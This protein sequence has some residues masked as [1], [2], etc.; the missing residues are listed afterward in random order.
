MAHKPKPYG[1]FPLI[2]RDFRVSN[3]QRGELLFDYDNNQLYFCKFT[4]GELMSAAREIYEQI[5]S[6]K[7]KNTKIIPYD[8][9]KEVPEDADKEEIKQIIAPPIKDREYNGFYFLIVRR[10][11]Y[12]SNDY[13]PLTAQSWQVREGKSFLGRNSGYNP[14]IGD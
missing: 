5:L 2:L 1:T 13:N 10:R 8:F 11:E 3:P 14:E 7:V 12:G 9:D 6:Y 4:T